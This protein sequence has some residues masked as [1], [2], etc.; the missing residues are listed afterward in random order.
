LA[1]PYHEH[2]DDRAMEP[3]TREKELVKKAMKKKRRRMKKEKTKRNGNLY[4]A[5]QFID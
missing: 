2:E 4:I 3:E 5:K 1:K